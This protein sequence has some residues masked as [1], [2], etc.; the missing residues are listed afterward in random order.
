MKLDHDLTRSL[1]LHIEEITDGKHG[2]SL[3]GFSADFSDYKP[4][5]VRYHV[6]YLCDAGFVEHN[7]SEIYDITPKGRDCL[8]SIRN[9]ET[10]R[11]TKAAIAKQTF[12]QLSLD[13]MAEVAK[14]LIAQALGI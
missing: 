11:Q 10:W 4:G 12:G 3:A 2:Y 5:V 1:L 7:D 13:V 6:K 9:P 14:R 8:D